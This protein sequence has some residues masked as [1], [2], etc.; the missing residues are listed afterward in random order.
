LLPFSECPQRLRIKNGLTNHTPF[1]TYI[2][3][4]CMVWASFNKKFNVDLDKAQIDS[5]DGTLRIFVENPNILESLILETEVPTIATTFAPGLNPDS[6]Q[7]FLKE[8]D[9]FRK[10][11]TLGRAIIGTYVRPQRVEEDLTIGLFPWSQLADNE[12]RPKLY[13]EPFAEFAVAKI[14]VPLGLP[15]ETRT[16]VLSYVVGYGER[17]GVNRYLLQMKTKFSS[18]SA[19]EN[20]EGYING[21]LERLQRALC[22]K[23]NA[24]PA[25]KPVI[26]L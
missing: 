18:W 19:E 11:P 25:E 7:T 22:K 12:L 9:I 13:E 15:N 17:H 3:G 16:K 10:L 4:I 23:L 2:L 21:T 24:E 26:R 1:K 20:V 6:K 14:A 8:T 5:T